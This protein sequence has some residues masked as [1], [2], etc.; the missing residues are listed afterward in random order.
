MPARPTSEMNHSPSSSGASAIADLCAATFRR[1]WR[2]GVRREDS[3]RLPTRGR[4]RAII[5]FSG[6]GTRVSPRSCGGVSNPLAPGRSSS[7]C[8][9]RSARMDSSSSRFRAVLAATGPALGARQRPGVLP[10]GIDPR[11]Q[12]LL[13]RADMDQRLLAGV[14]GAGPSRSSRAGRRASSRAHWSRRSRG[15]PRVLRPLHGPRD[16]GHGLR[17]VVAD[18]RNARP[19]PRT[20]ASFLDD[21]PLASRDSAE[22]SNDGS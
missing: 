19:R 13:A 1:N 7:R 10:T 5:R 12:A 18:R 17:L 14:A 2:E 8:L 11:D 21:P 9:R 22:T 4:A 6:T 15:P 20:A 16:R 3:V